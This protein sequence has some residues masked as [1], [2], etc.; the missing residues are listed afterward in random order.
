MPARVVDIQ[1]YRVDLDAEVRAAAEAI[2]AG[3]LVCL[4]TETVYGLA[5]N[6]GVASARA[7]LE[8][9][10]G[11]TPASP[12]TPHLPDAAAADAYLGDVSDVGRR[13]IAKLWPG[14]VAVSFAVDADRRAEVAAAMGCDESTFY[15]EGGRVTLRCPD[16]LT[17]RDVLAA[18]GQPV[19]LTR[20]GL[21]RGGDASRPPTPDTLPADVSTL[22]LAG[23]TRHSRPSTVIRV[24]GDAWTVV[25]EG[26]YDRRIIEKLLRTTVLFVCSGNTCRSPMAMALARR[27]I[28]DAVGVPATKLTE[29]GYDVI[30]AGTFAMPGMRA[31]PQ[32]ADA[33]A[34]RGGELASHR[35]QPVSVELIHR[36][37]LIVTMGRDHSAAVASLV[38]SSAGKTV[39]LDP[40][41]DI[42][43]PIG[44]SAE[45][46]RTLAGE[47]DR[48]LDVRL[49]ETV[50][51]GG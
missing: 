38:P 5:L 37:D 2:K 31:T 18:A 11:E 22:L 30:S 6:P 28:A 20:L 50:L 7:T 21:P 27:H 43:D 13:L 12:L 48:L 32:A 9:L 40:E 23:P 47:I 3:G 1:D 19:V 10:R 17:T 49:K 14:P 29:A 42:E 24:D 41:G 25:R 34:E 4:P 39:T 26:V 8:R 51:K 35:S 15:G 44:S 36:A 33:V 45:H 16:E 46:Y